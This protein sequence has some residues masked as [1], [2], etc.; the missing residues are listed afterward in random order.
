MGTSSVFLD[1]CVRMNSSAD[2][3]TH[4]KTSYSVSLYNGSTINTLNSVAKNIV[5]IR[6]NMSVF[7]EAGEMILPLLLELLERPQSFINYN[8]RMKQV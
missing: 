6:S 8:I 4:A 7:D 3:F 2:P 5:G 1:E